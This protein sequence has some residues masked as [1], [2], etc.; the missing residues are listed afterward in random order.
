MDL[1]KMLTNLS[2]DS[3]D[4]E[5][6]KAKDKI[7]AEM[8]NNNNPYVQTIGNFLL[9]Q[10]NINPGYADKIL[11]KDKS[12]MKSLDVMRKEAMKN[13]VGNCGVLSDEDGFKIV[14]KYYEMDKGV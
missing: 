5:V 13:K 3:Q 11:N 2:D 1:F 6:C 9:E 14:I 10:L 7:K 12:I 4:I 8:E